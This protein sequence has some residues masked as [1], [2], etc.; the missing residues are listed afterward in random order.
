MHGLRRPA[1]RRRCRARLCGR[2]AAPSI[3]K[4]AALPGRRAP[5]LESTAQARRD[6]KEACHARVHGEIALRHWAANLLRRAR[7]GEARQYVETPAELLKPRFSAGVHVARRQRPQSV[8]QQRAPLAAQ[9]GACS[10]PHSLLSECGSSSSKRFYNSV[11]HAGSGG[12][13]CKPALAP[14]SRRDKSDGKRD[15]GTLCVWSQCSAVWTHS[16]VASDCV[17]AL[18]IVSRAATTPL[19]GD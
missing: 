5:R 12:T 13:A 16:P 2:L 8:C 6:R 19:A 3:W 17:V 1:R 15:E 11:P 4:S 14:G 18:C 9:H 7:W 10:R